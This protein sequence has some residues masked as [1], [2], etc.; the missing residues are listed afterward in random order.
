MPDTELTVT[1]LMVVAATPKG[2]DPN[3]QVAGI[4]RRTP[5]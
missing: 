3:A 1:Q 2:M 5:G 4:S